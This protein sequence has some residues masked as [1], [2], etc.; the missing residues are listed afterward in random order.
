VLTADIGIYRPIKHFIHSVT[1]WHLSQ[2]LV[3]A[4]NTLMGQ[5]G[6]RHEV[7]A[8]G[9]L[10]FDYGTFDCGTFG[11]GQAWRAAEPA[12]GGNA[13]AGKVGAK[14]SCPARI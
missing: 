12:R 5:D 13:S 2:A 11:T 1:D 8:C 3:D 6:K 7:I 10:L 4:I 14:L 9:K